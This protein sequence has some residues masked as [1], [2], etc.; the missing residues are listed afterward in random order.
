[1]R[2]EEWVTIIMFIWVCWGMG[3]KHFF[4]LFLNLKWTEK[5]AKFCHGTSFKRFHH[6]KKIF[7]FTNNA[8]HW[9]KKKKLCSYMFLFI[10][11]SHTAPTDSSWPTD[12][13][14]IEKKKKKKGIIRRRDQDFGFWK[15]TVIKSGLLETNNKSKCEE[16]RKNGYKLIDMY[17]KTIPR[18]VIL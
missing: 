4:N 10:P 12:E 7:I 9:L 8:D 3:K 17:S 18:M 16:V 1:M 2:W 11:N 15:E 13:G 6:F 14:L 5:E